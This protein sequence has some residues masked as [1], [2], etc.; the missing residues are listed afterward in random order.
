MSIPDADRGTTRSDAVGLIELVGSDGRFWIGSCGTRPDFENGAR[1]KDDQSCYYFYYDLTD[2]RDGTF[3]I[4][5]KV[6]SRNPFGASIRMSDF[7]QKVKLI[8]NIRFFFNTRDWFW[9]HA[10]QRW[11]NIY[12]ISRFFGTRRHYRCHLGDNRRNVQQ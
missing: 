12:E 6:I 9:P 2:H 3:S 10:P 1:Y 5:V 8:N 7:N 11:V 4:H